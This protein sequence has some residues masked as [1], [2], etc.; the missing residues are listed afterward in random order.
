MNRRFLI[1]IAIVAGLVGFCV[2]PLALAKPGDRLGTRVI[3]YVGHPPAA[4]A[5]TDGALLRPATL[6]VLET[7]GV[8]GAARMMR[9]QDELKAAYRLERLEFQYDKE[10]DLKLGVAQSAPSPAPGVDVSLKLVDVDEASGTYAVRLGE[11][12]KQPVET[13]IT[14]K[15]GSYSIVGGRNG[16]QAP[17]FFVFVRP[18]TIAE[19]AEEA[20]W[21]GKTRPTVIQ[22]AQPKYPE[23]AR[24]AKL[25]DV[26]VL[27]LD[28]DASGTVAGAGVL[29]GTVP[30]LVEA[31]RSAALQWKFE[32]AKDAAGKP[33][34]SKC[35]LTIAFKLE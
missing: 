9:L 19:E 32:P 33:F 24:S 11:T 2:A 1:A 3:L 23:E 26:V 15:R 6:I 16:P 8:E 17:Y 28:I 10:L 12:G 27:E 29:E 5:S 13:T 31:A 20:K 35:V 22:K 14:V 7:Q 21:E 25:M 18:S 34:A 4:D 30:T